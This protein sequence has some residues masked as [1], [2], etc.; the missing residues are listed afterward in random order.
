MAQRGPVLGLDFG[1]SNSAAGYLCNGA[2]R[3]IG[4]GP[5]QTTLP[6]TFF[7]DFDTR[8]TLIGEAANQALLDGIEGR[9]MRALKRVLGT[10]LMH[11]ERQILNERV[12][13]VDIIARFL[14]HIKT[15]AEAQAGTRFDRVLSG[16]PVVFHGLNDPREAGA[17]ADLRACYRAAGFDEVDFMPEPEAAAIASGALEQTGEV[18]LIVDIGGGTSDFSVF[19]STPDGVSVLANHGVRIGGTD[20]DRAISIERVMPLLGKGSELRKV[21]GPGASPVPNAIFNDLATWEKIPF[22]YTP[23]T[24]R[25]VAELVQMAFEPEKLGR[26]ANLLEN[27]LGHEV[28]F[29]VERGK[30][31]ANAG[32][33]TSV[34]ALDQIE[35]GLC[36]ALPPEA[37]SACLAAH[38][39]MLGTGLRET[40]GFAGIGAADIDRVIY[41]GGSSLMS[42][43]SDVV[44]AECPDA[45]HSF[46]EVFTAV[47]D[48][49]AIAAARG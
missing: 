40:L 1:T 38:A 15:H 44:K 31:A 6:T 29:A 39:R 16:R 26:L 27:E 43:V 7:F 8:K 34:I 35:R 46:S 2:P 19:R 49:L 17:E 25:M 48:G 14:N 41:V 45:R 33:G 4:M 36:A 24:R 9:F 18:G 20:F 23:Q 42:V 21:M 47:T 10:P 3:L 11:E 12:T 28:A 5:G 37:L 13:F 22:L 32:H 30:I